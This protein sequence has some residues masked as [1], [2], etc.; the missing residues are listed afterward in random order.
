MLTDVLLLR[1][2]LV[3]VRPQKTIKKIT[4][5]KY[6]LTSCTPTVHTTVYF[7]FYIVPSCGFRFSDRLR[8][9]IEFIT[10]LKSRRKYTNVR[11]SNVQK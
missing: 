8:G 11:I 1:T 3:V 4:I 10:V 5:L 6:L 9:G 7:S 2:Q